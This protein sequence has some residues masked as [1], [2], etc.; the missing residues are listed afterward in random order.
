M[1]PFAG[2]GEYGL[3]TEPQRHREK[4]LD[5]KARIADGRAGEQPF[6]APPW[7]GL[8]HQSLKPG[9]PETLKS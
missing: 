2:P 6:E 7:L 9:N 3:A 1:G 8:N 4:A 5:K